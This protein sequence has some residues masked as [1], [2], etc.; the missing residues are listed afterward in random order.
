MRHMDMLMDYYVWV[1][2]LKRYQRQMLKLA[3][4]ILS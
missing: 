3:N 2:M 1:A 4:I